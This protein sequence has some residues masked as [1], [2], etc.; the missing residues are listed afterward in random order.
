MFSTKGRASEAIFLRA[1]ELIMLDELGALADSL[2]YARTLLSKLYVEGAA[3]EDPASYREDLD[4]ASLEKERLEAELA[5]NS[6]DFRNLQDALDI[7]TEKIVDILSMLPITSIL[8]EYM[9]YDYLPLDPDGS[10]PHYLAVTLDGSG[11]ISLQDLGEAS[12]I[13]SLIDEYRSHLLTVSSTGLLPTI[14][15]RTDYERVGRALYDRVWKPIEEQISGED[16]VFIAPDGGLNMISFAGLIDDEGEFLVERQPV[17][18]LSSGRDLMRLKDDARSGTGLFALG[19]PD[20]DAAPEVRLSL[21]EG[22]RAEQPSEP[23]FSAVRNVRTACAELR[24]ITLNRLPG[25]KTEVEQIAEN[26]GT[27]TGPTTVCFGTIASE[28]KFKQEAPGKRVIHLATHGYFL[29]GKCQPVTT[30]RGFDSEVGYVGENPLLLSGLFLA[31]A[32][33][34]GEGADDFGAEDGILTAE[35]VTAMN[36]SGADLV[37]LSACETGLGEVKEGEGVYGLRRAFQMAGARTVI[38]ALWSVSDKETAEIMA[39]LYG[40]GRKSLPELMR[41]IQLTK[42]KTLRENKQADHPF[43]WGAF[44]ALGDWR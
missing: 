1:R 15:E 30:Q 23:V 40:A 28:E 8:I 43:S 16:L 2:R 42:I 38:S 21:P 35:E 33:L 34:H 9:K 41:E 12:G 6:E 25:T 44:I 13:D 29:E 24:G 27:A 18:Y 10:V 32:N 11:A 39:Q 37:V 14:V 19:D 17:H 31:G 4:G 3:E 36:L 5:R 7:S 26:W 22:A 20:F